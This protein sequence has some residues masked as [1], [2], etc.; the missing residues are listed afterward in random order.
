MD[1]NTDNITLGS[2]MEKLN[3]LEEVVNK[4]SDD[5][6]HPDVGLYSRVNKNTHFR[7]YREKLEIIVGTAFIVQA[8]AW[9]FLMLRI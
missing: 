6:M 2:V 8:I 9:I 7:K 1:I 3:K 4:L 5:I